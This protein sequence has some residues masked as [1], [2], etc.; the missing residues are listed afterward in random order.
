MDLL[1]DIA[2]LKSIAEDQLRLLD[3]TEKTKNA[4][5]LPFFRALGYDPFD[6]RE[7]EPGCTVDPNGNGQANVDYAIKKEEA[8]ILLVQCTEAGTDLDAWDPALLFRSLTRT[9]AQI[10]LLTNGLT[11]RFYGEIE[12][13]PSADVQ[14]FFEFHLFEH[15][16]HDLEELAQ[17]TKPRFD[18][19]EILET[20]RELKYERRLEAY[21]ARQRENPDD[22][23]VQF[24][25][26]QVADGEELPGGTERFESLVRTTLRNFARDTERARSDRPTRDE[27]IDPTPT[28]KNSD[29]EEEATDWTRF[30]RQRNRKPEQKA[31]LQ[32]ATTPLVEGKKDEPREE[33]FYEDTYE[34]NLA[35]LI[36]DDFE[37]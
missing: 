3:T 22:Q 20:A 34:K 9:D 37:G 13:D 29:P 14:P 12:G 15:A 36:V 5:L 30:L 17:F 25:A 24:L 18:A 32:D 7:V 27:S 1:E 6:T 10:G 21:L 35:E 33:G 23:F 31:A 8:P 28:T 26:E 11:Y 4:L 2:S 19:D 16:P